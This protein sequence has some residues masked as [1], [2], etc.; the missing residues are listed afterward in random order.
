MFGFSDE[1]GTLTISLF[2][3]GYCVGPIIWAPL[4]EQY[5]RRP[6]FI[7]P[8]IIFLVRLLDLNPWYPPSLT[9]HQQALQVGTAVAKN[10]GTLLVLRFLG[11]T[12]AAAPLSNSGYAS[13]SSHLVSSLIVSSALIADIW[14]PKERG[15]ALAAFVV[16]PFAGPGIGPT[17]GGYI[18]QSGA[19]WRWVIWVVVFF[20]SLL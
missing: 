3:A 14:G 17:I 11:G 6:I 16:A 2:V 12:F 10:T 1:V 18:I 7:G 13:T 8:F 4:S 9:Y 20:V 5:G 19:H 15:V